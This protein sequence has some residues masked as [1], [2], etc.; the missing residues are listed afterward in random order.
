MTSSTTRACV[1]I[2]SPYLGSF[3]SYS[4][5]AKSDLQK[6]K[7]KIKNTKKH[8]KHKSVKNPDVCFPY[9]TVEV[10][11]NLECLFERGQLEFQKKR[12]T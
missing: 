7:I 4:S 8:T 12:K 10:K 11:N 2:C 3:S 5:E 1:I 9:N 6:L